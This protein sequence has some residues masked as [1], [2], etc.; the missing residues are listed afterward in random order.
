MVIAQVLA[1]GDTSHTR[2]RA[3]GDVVNVAEGVRHEDDQ[4]G[5]HHANGLQ[6]RKNELEER[7]VH[8]ARE[9][10]GA[11]RENAWLT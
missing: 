7:A 5:R 6:G 1:P 4:E 8:D 9:V 3:P 2:S 10:D 11:N